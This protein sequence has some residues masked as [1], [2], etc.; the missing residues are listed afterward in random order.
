MWVEEG[1]TAGPPAAHGPD[2]LLFSGL[3]PELLFDTGSLQNWLIIC[4]SSNIFWQ[5][6]FFWYLPCQLWFSASSCTACS[7]TA[8][9]MDCVCFSRTHNATSWGSAS[10][11]VK[12]SRTSRKRVKIF[13]ILGITFFNFYNST[14]RLAAVQPIQTQCPHNYTKWS[15][16]TYCMTV[17]QYA[18]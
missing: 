1:K 11:W 12:C 18:C 17:T 2:P 13:K 15:F 10:T 3:W 14:L 7:R 5:K 8:L 9:F 4:H 16:M 6:V